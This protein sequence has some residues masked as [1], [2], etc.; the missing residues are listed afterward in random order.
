MEVLTI[1]PARGGS[2]GIP[3]KNV[4]MVGGKPLLAHSI[5]AAIASRYISR[6]VVSTDDVEIAAVAERYGA[7]VVWRPNE[8]SGDSAS[9]ESA[10]L[11]VLEHLASAEDYRPDL[12][13]FLQ[14]TSPLTTAQDIDGTINALIEQDADS[15]LAVTPF[16]YFLWQEDASG[17][18]VGINHDKMVRLPR[19]QR[20][21]QFVETGAV[22]IMRAEQFRIAGHRF[23]GRT[24]VYTMP[25]ERHWEI[26]E[27]SDL[28]VAES[29]LAMRHQKESL[30][31]LPDRVS[32]LVL[33]FD[34]VFTDNKVVVLDDGAEAVVCHR[35]DGMGL[36]LLKELPIKIWVLSSEVNAVVQRRCE[37]LGLPYIQGLAGDKRQAL[38]GILDQ[39][40]ILLEEVVYVGNDV[41]DL[42]PMRM[43]GCSV[44]VS[45]SHPDV[46]RQ[47]NLILRAAGGNGAIRELCDLLLRR[48]GKSGGA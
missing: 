39:E 30:A 17:N 7:D 8:I 44:A 10:L 4:R 18:A 37:K 43:V 12:V 22:Y 47:A 46:L 42:A 2:K 21:P 20:E 26:D 19:Q 45:D 27:P 13:A 24:A 34:G 14:C 6:V 40:Q 29:L 38:L 9:S 1:I 48:F 5:E 16:H 36:S 31:V 41:N 25:T 3:R 11:H 32:A 15:A 23:F 35:G 28:I 33:D